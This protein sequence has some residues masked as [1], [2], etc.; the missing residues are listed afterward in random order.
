MTR[1]G[2]LGRGLDALIP[3][4][5]PMQSS[6][7]RL[8]AVDEIRPNPRQPRSYFD[9]GELAELAES[10]RQHGVIQPLIVSPGEDDSYYI[11]IAGERRLLA[12]KLAGLQ[13]VP[14]L[15]RAADEQQRLELALIEN[16]QR[17]DLSPLEAGEAYRQMAEE[18]DLSHEVI[19]GRVGKSRAVIT[20]TLRLLRLPEGVRQALTQHSISEGHARALLALPTAEAQSAALQTILNQDLTV[21]QTEALV[22]RLNGERPPRPLRAG[23]PPE[24]VDLQQR[25]EAT[26]GTK[27]TLQRRRG[28]GTLVLH[29]YSDE[30]LDALVER[31][32][33]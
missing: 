7:V 6:G 14:V 23:P 21:R 31:L 33:Q 20:N 27:V 29:F 22:R 30:E 28:K 12:A 25:L 11:L 16:V 26:L 4:G 15:V 3:G 18:F 2:G 1:K 8:V 5:E 24:E 13:D 19:A 10:I 32:L 17:A 9:T